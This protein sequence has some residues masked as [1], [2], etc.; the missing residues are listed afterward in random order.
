MVS[1]SFSLLM[2]LM[3]H[4][5]TLKGSNLPWKGDPVTGRHTHPGSIVGGEQHWQATRVVPGIIV[6][7]TGVS[8]AIS[9]IQKFV[10]FPLYLLAE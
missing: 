1:N 7:K 6:S 8:S 5:D 4:S 10:P 3:T 9:N 2:G